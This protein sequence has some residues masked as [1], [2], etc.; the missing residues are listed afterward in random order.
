MK[1]LGF[2]LFLAASLAL[3]GA[4]SSQNATAPEP[5]KKERLA[6]LPAEER[7]WLTEFVAP[8]IQPEEQKLFLKLTEPHQREIFKEAFWARREQDGLERPMGPGFRQRYEELRQ[9]ADEKYDGWRNDAGR[10]VLRWGEP[11]SLEPAKSCAESTFRDLEIWTYAGRGAGR[12]KDVYFF[13]RSAPL[14]PRKLWFLGARDSDVFEPN[15]C[16]KTFEALAADCR[17]SALDSCFSC[18]D[19]CTVYEAW[20]QIRFRQGSAAGGFAEVARVL[21]PPK[22]ATEDLTQLADRFPALPDPK[23]KP[24]DVTGP[25]GFVRASDVQATTTPAPPAP[26]KELSKR[27]SIAA[28]PEDDRKWLTEFVAPII[29]PEEEKLFL[30]LT[31]GPQREIFKKAF[32]ARRE[33]DG[34]DFPMGPGYRG[35]Y[36]NLRRLADDTYDGWRRDAGRMVIALGEPASI[37]RLEACKLNFKDLEIWTYNRPGSGGRG[38]SRHFLYRK[39]PGQPRILWTLGTADSDVF[40]AGSCYGTFEELG[41]ACRPPGQA[42]GIDRCDLSAC[43]DA[44]AVHQAYKEIQSRQGSPT[45]AKAEQARLLS[46]PQVPLEDL[47][48]LAAR[49]AAPSVTPASSGFVRASTVQTTTSPAAVPQTAPPVPAKQLSKK[50]SL[51]ALP[52]DDR[53]WLTEFVAPIIQPEEE[54]LFLQLTEPHQREIFKEAFWARREQQNLNPPMG[55]GYRHRYAELRQLADEKYDGWRNDAGRMVIARG[56]PAAINELNECGDMMRNLEVWTYTGL[57]GSGRGR[58]QHLFYRPSMAGARRLW[59]TGIPESEL[60]NPG[61]RPLTQTE[62]AQECVRGIQQPLNPGLPRPNRECICRLYEIIQQAKAFSS[63]PSEAGRLL[64]PEK[65]STEDLQ[66]VADGFPALPDPKAKTIGVEGPGSAPTQPADGG[67]KVPTS[68]GA[69]VTAATS[70]PAPAHRKLN[71]KEV[72]ELTARLA[73]KYREWLQLVELI[74]TDTEREVFLQIAD[75]YQ[76]DRFIESFWRRRSLDSQGIRNDYQA[77]H[78]HR[79]ELAKSQ[80]KHLNNDRAKMLII[81]G[82]PDSVIAIDCPEVYVPIQIWYYDRLESLKSKVYLIFYTPYGVGEMKLWLPLDGEG[83][84]Q[85]GGGFGGGGAGTR[86]APG[87]RVDYDRCTETRTLRQAIAYSSA[88]LGSGASSLAGSGKLFQPPIVETEGIDQILSMTTELATG[89]VPLG[90]AK[91]V[92]FPEMR[93]NKIG[94]DLSLLV[95]KSDLKSR[96]LGEEKFYNVDVIGEVVKGDRLIDNFKYRF[97]IPTHEVGGEKIPLTVR[98]YLYPGEYNLV[99]KVSDGNQ[100][101]EGRI[102]DKLAV[103]EQPDAP[104]PQVAAARAEGRA[105]VEKARD[106]GLLPSAIALLPVAKEIVT[107]LQRFET[108]AADGVKAVDFYLNGSK[109]MTKTRPPFDA[110][111]NLGPLPRKH[112]VR[113]VAYGTAGRAIGEDE[114]TVNEGREMFRVRIMT[115]EKGSRVS[116]P[117][118]VVAAVAVPEGKSLQKLEIYSNERRV[119]TLYQPPFE[120]TVNISEGKSLGYVRI[121]GTLDD[122][123]LSEDLRYVNAPAYIS[124]V[125]VDAVELYTTVTDKGRPVPGLQ[126]SNFKVF[127]D[128]V[129]QKVESFEYVKNLPL[130]L[131][132]IV[133]TS[134]SMLESLA[135]TQAAALSFLDFS[136]GEKDRAFTVSFDNEPYLL[137]KLTNRKDRLFR[138]LAGL[139]AEGSTALYDA[140]IYGLYQFTGVKGK[141][142]LVVLSDGKDTASKFDYETLV[143]YVKRAGISIYGIGLKISGADLEV[144]YKLNKLAQSTGGQTFY[145]DSAKNLESVYRQINEDLRSQYLLTY[146]STNATGKEKWRKVEIKVEPS[147]LQARAITGYYP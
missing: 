57:G 51:A 111:L 110:D 139:R 48:T 45:G 41:K 88:V 20:E 85:V 4:G 98:R 21:A 22:V 108:R 24:L 50:E 78:T 58:T 95:A 11:D 80:F 81:N 15:G 102:T 25:S 103:P 40:V 104:P 144:K 142:A 89:S 130:T 90:V 35:R 30:T 70:T 114:Y 67:A 145:V 16:R 55:L 27:E 10:M 75:D 54:K 119:A 52:E 33:K 73:P 107:G 37:D 120:Q 84:L 36:E 112:T 44:C 131:G 99:L 6:A 113:V 97:D 143:E 69:K 63:G 146:Y 56:E 12:L 31:E 17:P 53:K 72:K 61:Q 19:R 76:K 28:L 18:P 39:G 93:A 128:G 127:E 91:L 29:H 71:G 9:L 122:G 134:A 87:R 118:R 59:H 86:S 38:V 60:Y 3:P 94:V 77:V 101:A 133:D 46:T 106:L 74:V 7:K 32:W 132:V 116:G 138:S 140:I 121:V 64:A 100:S 34:L 2:L 14:A 115:P 105:T 68:A 23:A 8:I 117:T 83:V 66:K 141:K 82:P 123:T 96:D 126:A 135:E 49:L 26:A 125:S 65:V 62:Q 136:V 43:T 1:R 79:V 129:I 92:R 124:E 13:Y 47:P 42:G 5:S 147:S 137:T 109:M